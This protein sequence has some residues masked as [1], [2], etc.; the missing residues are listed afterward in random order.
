[1]SDIKLTDEVLQACYH[2]MEF[3]F[4]HNEAAQFVDAIRALRDAAQATVDDAHLDDPAN[5]YVV[6]K[7]RIYALIDLLPDSEVKP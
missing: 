4:G 1:M 5:C 6:P 7:R 2:S 3:H